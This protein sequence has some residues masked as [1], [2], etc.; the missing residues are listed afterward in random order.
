MKSTE[1]FRRFVFLSV[2]AILAVSTPAVADGIDAGDAFEKL[3]ALA[4]T[5]S[6]HSVGE[7]E[8][9]DSDHDDMKTV[10]QIQVSANGS[11]VMETMSPGSP[12][13]MINM[14]HLDGAELVLTHYCAG[15][16]QPT[17][18]L[19]R[20]E[21]SSSD[22]VFEFTGGSNLDPKVDNHI[23]DARITWEGDDRIM[24]QWIAYAN[25]ERAGKMT[26]ALERG[27]D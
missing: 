19:N 12:H 11:V 6:G 13:E 22:M 10:H 3:K 18:R 27:S 26:F 25:G 1:F 7:G 20:S 4:G 17:M 14:Y 2:V 5:W 24:S 9:K 21:S 15:G 23:H 16:N 8:A